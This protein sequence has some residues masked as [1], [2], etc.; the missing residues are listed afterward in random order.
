M[1]QSEVNAVLNRL[2][3]V[4]CRSLPAYLAEAKPWCRR[5]D[6][7]VQEALNYLVADQRALAVQVSRAILKG[8][9]QDPGRFPIEFTAMN[10]VEIGSLLP[11]LIDRQ[12]RDIEALEQCVADLADAPQIRSLAEEALGNTK[13]HLDTLEEMAKHE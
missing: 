11:E 4:L 12:R 6:H 3:H 1:D 13:G 9:R 2:L 10:D 5:S 8:G 7:P